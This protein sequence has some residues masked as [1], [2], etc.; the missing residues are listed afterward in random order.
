M[1][2]RLVLCITVV[3]ML[4]E[5]TALP[6]NHQPGQ[7][8]PVQHFLF[9]VGQPAEHFP[10][11]AMKPCH[12]TPQADPSSTS[13]GSNGS[14]G[15][16]GSTHTSGGLQQ[17]PQSLV[18][19][20]CDITHLMRS[21]VQQLYD[22]CPAAFKGC[23]QAAAD[24]GADATAASMRKQQLQKMQAAAEEVST[25]LRAGLST[26]GGSA[27]AAAYEAWVQSLLQGIIAAEADR[28][29]G[30]G[31]PACKPWLLQQRR[32]LHR[33][34]VWT[35]ARQAPALLLASARGKDSSACNAVGFR[36]RLCMCRA[37][38]FEGC[39]CCLAVQQRQLVLALPTTMCYYP[40][41]TCAHMHRRTQTRVHRGTQT[42]QSTRRHA[43]QP[44][45]VAGATDQLL[46][47]ADIC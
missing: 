33:V 46:R 25:R 6:A 30:Q 35:T 19:G 18:A 23:A 12:A 4:R 10:A 39:C 28:P 32:F 27:T 20:A 24:E 37:I 7:P 17:P 9:F 44:C 40:A 11:G 43:L 3:Q 8:L 38:V 34:S 14:S 1:L 21:L 5:V 31:G 2:V 41:R 47:N 45:N 42:Q 26:G 16:T 13:S 36:L 15:N 22:A 29:G